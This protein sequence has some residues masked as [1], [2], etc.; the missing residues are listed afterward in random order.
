M[1]AAAAASYPYLISRIGDPIFALVIGTSS[2]YIRIQ[3][4]QRERI[5]QQQQEAGD[6]EKGLVGV[7]PPPPSVLETGS[8]RLRMWWKGEFRGL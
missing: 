1:A 8:R 4:E 2:A 7:G 5:K 6:S 3:R